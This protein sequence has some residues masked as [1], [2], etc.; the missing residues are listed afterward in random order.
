M[1]ITKPSDW[2]LVGRVV[3]ANGEPGVT[4]FNRLVFYHRS[5]SDQREC[6]RVNTSSRFVSRVKLP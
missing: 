3:H 2:S 5:V 4:D 6:P 1:A